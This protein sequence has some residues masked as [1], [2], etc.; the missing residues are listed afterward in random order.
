M[1]NSRFSVL[2]G[3]Q[4]KIL[5][6]LLFSL[7]LES[8]LLNVSCTMIYVAITKLNTPLPCATLILFIILILV[9]YISQVGL[10]NL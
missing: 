2:V 10:E 5:S 7:S 8:D 3:A 1:A 4:G 6:S 9:V